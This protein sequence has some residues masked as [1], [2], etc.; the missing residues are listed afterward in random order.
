MKAKLRLWSTEGDVCDNR[1]PCLSPTTHCVFERTSI[2]PTL[3]TQSY[4]NLWHA[5]VPGVL[6]LGWNLNTWSSFLLR[7]LHTY[8]CDNEPCF[9]DWGIPNEFKPHQSRFR[10]TRWGVS[11][12]RY[13][14]SYR[15]TCTCLYSGCWRKTVCSNTVCMW[16]S[17]L[18]SHDLALGAVAFPKRGC[19]FLLNLVAF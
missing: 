17:R 1:T 3:D 10:L 6:C 7:R 8:T 14:N 13:T 2:K 15:S 4:F 18:R 12:E 16:D 11:R 19:T 5:A 9:S